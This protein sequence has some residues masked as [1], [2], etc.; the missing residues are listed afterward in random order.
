MLFENQ[1]FFWFN[2]NGD[3]GFFFFFPPSLCRNKGLCNASPI[4]VIPLA[5]SVVHNVKIDA[6][7]L[8][9]YHNT[10]P[11]FA[12]CHHNKIK[13]KKCDTQL[14]CLKCPLFAPSQSVEVFLRVKLWPKVD[15]ILVNISGNN[16]KHFFNKVAR[17][18]QQLHRVNPKP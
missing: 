16:S 14:W 12:R 3:K 2:S 5:E 8:F 4:L 7:F 17:C 6:S 10:R 18:F 15:S 13:Q 1:M 11:V 9:L